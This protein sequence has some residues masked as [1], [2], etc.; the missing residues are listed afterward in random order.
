MQ[1][2]KQIFLFI[3]IFCINALPERT[4]VHTARKSTKIKWLRIFHGHFQ[5]RLIRCCPRSTFFQ[6][7]IRQGIDFSFSVPEIIHHIQGFLLCFCNKF[8]SC[9]ICR[10]HDLS[11]KDSCCHEYQ[12]RKDASKPEGPAALFAVS[13]STGTGQKIIDL[14]KNSHIES[15][16]DSTLRFLPCQHHHKWKYKDF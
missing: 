9:I 15:H 2:V 6:L 10:R 4:I 8:R 12:T 3:G 14:Q 5:C 7:S 11:Q 1:P 16:A 13:L